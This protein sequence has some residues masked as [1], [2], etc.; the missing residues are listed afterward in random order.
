MEKADVKEK[1]LLQVNDIA[2]MLAIHP[3]TMY[4]II[5]KDETFPKPITFGPRMRRWRVED[6]KSWIQSK[7]EE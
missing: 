7:L 4:S 6:I 1:L 2:A 3:K 5:Q